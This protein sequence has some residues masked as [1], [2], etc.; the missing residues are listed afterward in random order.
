MSVLTFK[1]SRPFAVLALLGIP[2]LAITSVVLLAASIYTVGYSD[3]GMK[4]KIQAAFMAA[5]SMFLV[6][7]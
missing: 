3:L 6:M 2:V 7:S 4:L 1:Y 5:L